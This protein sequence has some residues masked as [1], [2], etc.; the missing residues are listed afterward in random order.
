MIQDDGRNLARNGGSSRVKCAA[1]TFI[2]T[3][4]TPSWVQFAWAKDAAEKLLSRKTRH[5]NIEN[6]MH[7]NDGETDRYNFSWLTEALSQI[8][9][10]LS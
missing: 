10:P 2:T 7:T 9:F 5:I 4:D 3:N 8:C 1:D 6:S